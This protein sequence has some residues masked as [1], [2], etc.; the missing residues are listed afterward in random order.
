MS[1]RPGRRSRRAASGAHPRARCPG[2]LSFEADSRVS[3]RSCLLHAGNGTPAMR[4]AGPRLTADVAGQEGFEP[5]TR[6]FGDRCS[7]VGATG[8]IPADAALLRFL[9]CRVLAAARAEL[10]ELELVLLL[11]LVLGRRVV[12]LLAVGA[13]AMTARC[14]LRMLPIGR[15]GASLLVELFDWISRISRPRRPAPTVRPPS[16]MA[17]RSSFSMAIGVISSTSIAMLSPGI[18]IS[19]P[20]RQLHRCR[21]RRSCG[22][23]TAAGSR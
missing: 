8:L 16:R 22:S 17:K 11:L 5:P 20:C 23:R 2:L 12:P 10:G 18:T 19:T 6:G 21:S 7:T 1:P 14:I 15:V 4:T 3:G 13:L 9:V